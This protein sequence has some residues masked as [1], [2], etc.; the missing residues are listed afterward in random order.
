[1]KGLERKSGLTNLGCWLRG[2][3]RL[4]EVEYISI[5]LGTFLIAG[6]F[7]DSCQRGRAEAILVCPKAGSI[8]S[9]DLWKLPNRQAASQVATRILADVFG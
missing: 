1:M 4:P 9:L 5:R 2:A 8:L 7:W 6:F 3:G